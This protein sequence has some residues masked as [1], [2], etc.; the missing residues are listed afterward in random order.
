MFDVYMCVLCVVCVCASVY[1]HVCVSVAVI[2]KRFIT[3]VSQ[4]LCGQ[5]QSLVPVSQGGFNCWPALGW[6]GSNRFMSCYYITHNAL[7]FSLP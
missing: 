1:E 5:G 4:R 2:S 3:L 6:S 7:E